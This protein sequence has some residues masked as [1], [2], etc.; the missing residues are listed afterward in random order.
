MKLK[1]I[2]AL[3]GLCLTSQASAQVVIVGRPD[4]VL[5]GGGWRI[6][7]PRGGVVVAGGPYPGVVLVPQTSI[8]IK[9]TI[10][11]AKRPILGPGYDQ[12]TRGVDLDLVPPNR[13][14]PNESAAPLPR[15]SEGNQGKPLPGV[16]VSK[17]RPSV[18][19]GDLVQEMKV[20][21]KE[22]VVK[23][24]MPPAQLPRD[25]KGLMELGIAEFRAGD[26]GLAAQRFRRARDS[27]PDL[28]QAYFLLAQ[29]EFAMGQYRDAVATIHAGMALDKQWPRLA[30]HPRLDLYQGREADYADHLQRL[31]NSVAAQ[32]N[33]PAL[34]F[35][36]AHQLWFDGRR[37]DA[38]ALFQRARPLSANP[39]FVDMFLAAG[40]PG[41]MAS[42]RK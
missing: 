40:A 3:V 13:A 21:P 42:N 29:T 24:P 30:I 5:P 39:S 14:K 18:R 9:T 8:I 27:K 23:P 4:G 11:G 36:M 38:L 37:A 33:Q 1:A 20:P 10:V 19:P 31:G 26:F 17:S 41:Q 22:Q 7:P 16:D 28:S 25:E 35:L 6:G 34:L 12:D 32:P 2:A 15:H